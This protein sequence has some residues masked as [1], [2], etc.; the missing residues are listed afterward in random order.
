MKGRD[1]NKNILA[2]RELWLGGG[3]H[4]G[5]VHE[6]PGGGGPEVSRERSA[7]VGALVRGAGVPDDDGGPALVLQLPLPHY[8]DPA[9]GRV[10][11]DHLTHTLYSPP[12]PHRRADYLV[13]TPKYLPHFSL[14]RPPKI[15]P[16][17]CK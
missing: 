3:H 9:P 16:L 11:A 12:P 13:L 5:L 8:A 6:E 15:C 14:K 7:G 17:R 4:G 2:A 10:V 1:Q